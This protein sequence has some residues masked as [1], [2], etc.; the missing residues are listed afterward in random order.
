[1]KTTSP[2]QLAVF[3][4]VLTTFLTFVII[5]INLSVTINMQWLFLFFTLGIVFLS[6]FLIVNFSLNRFIF[7]KINPIYKTIYNFNTKE[8]ELK[9]EIG[10]KG[11]M[12]DINREVMLWAKNKTKEIAQLKQLERYRKEFLGNVMHELR[13]PIFNIQGY[14]LTLLDGG[15]EDANVNRAYLE[16]AEKSINR[17][18]S[19]VE[20]LESISR[21]ESGSLKLQNEVFDLTALVRDVFE[22]QEIAANTMNIKL[23]LQQHPDK[24]VNVYADR[25]RIFEVINNLVANSIKYGISNGITRVAFL[26]VGDNILTEIS[27][28]G[29]GID[30]KHIPRLFERFFRIDKSRSRDMG[31]TGLGLSIVKH[32]IEAHN[33]TINVRSELDKGST[34]SFSLQKYPAKVV[35]KSVL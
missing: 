18:V 9:K 17:I 35:V 1:M 24:P 16:R 12:E 33:Q 26:D 7:E 28:D 32:I 25:R 29:I 4:S 31:G 20:D 30:E 8:E 15:L 23:I 2:R 27:D 6:I 22:S 11:I 10:K 5:L 3:L 21:L 14:V 13:T 19:I 34:F